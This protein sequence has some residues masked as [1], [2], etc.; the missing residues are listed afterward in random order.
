MATV[1]AITLVK[2]PGLKVELLVRF[3]RRSPDKW[4]PA[5]GSL[6]STPDGR[7]ADTWT[8][9]DGAQRDGDI[10]HRRQQGL[11]G[12]SIFKSLNVSAPA[13]LCLLGQKED[14]VVKRRKRFRGIH[15]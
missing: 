8:P 11:S 7:S 9:E 3:S 6:D 5:H 14:V 12:G 2:G 15:S 1:V 4:Q 10:M 13:P